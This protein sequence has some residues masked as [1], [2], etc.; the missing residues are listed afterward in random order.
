MQ[1]Q[2]LVHAYLIISDSGGVQEEAPALGKP[3]LDA[4][5]GLDTVKSLNWRDFETL[6]G[7]VFR[8][9]G[10]FVLE[11]A[12][13][14][15]D[16]EVDLRLRKDGKKVYVQCKHWKAKQVGVKIV[17]ELYGV[18]TGKSAD[19]GIVVTYGTFP[20]E[21]RDFAK[22]KPI[23]L[24]GAFLAVQSDLERSFQRDGWFSSDRE[25]LPERR[26]ESKP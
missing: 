22:G 26:C 11:N 8:R 2:N 15:P 17:R 18:M 9:K 13:T 21:A 16:G 23:S 25:R 3:V 6:V 20:K 14:G 4:Q 24:I 7:E 5:K 10:Y 19:E 12:G 1:W